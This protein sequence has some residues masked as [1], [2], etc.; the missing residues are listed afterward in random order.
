MLNGA[1]QQGR[2]RPFAVIYINDQGRRH[3]D[4]GLSERCILIDS[5]GSTAPDAENITPNS[6]ATDSASRISASSRSVVCSNKADSAR[7]GEFSPI[8]SLKKR[9]RCKQTS[10]TPIECA[11]RTKLG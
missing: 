1:I 9:S 10:L 3:N 11:S 6:F 5:P 4:Q 7:A 2:T 8:G